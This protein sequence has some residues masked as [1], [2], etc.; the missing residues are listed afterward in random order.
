MFYIVLHPRICSLLLDTG[1]DVLAVIGRTRAR[2]LQTPLSN[3]EFE[4][5]RLIASG[6]TVGDIAGRLSLSV[7][8]SA[9]TAHEFSRRYF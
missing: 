9:P 5:L 8:R 6:Q 7:R 3:R 1:F 4:V 2:P